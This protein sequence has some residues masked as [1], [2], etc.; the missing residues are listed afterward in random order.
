MSQLR[1]DPTTREWVIIA[2]E[3]AARPHSF[4]RTP[5]PR[6]TSR[7]GCPFCPGQESKTPPE[8]LVYAQDGGW[9]VRVVPNL[10]AA[11]TPGGSTERQIADGHFMAM[12]GVGAH[13]VVI[14][15]PDHD[16]P[17]ALMSDEEVLA[18]LRAY[19]ERYRALKESPN[20]SFV[21]IFKNH[22][23]RAGTSLDHPHSQIVATP[24]APL[25]VR[26]KFEIATDYY[27]ARGSCLYCDV[28]KWEREA[29]KRVVA[30][31]DGFVVIHPYASRSPFETWILPKTH[32]PCFD[33]AEEQGLLDLARVLRT[34]LRKIYHALG[35]PDFNYIL[36]TAPVDDEDNPYFLCHIQIVPRLTTVAGFEMGSGIYINT[37]LPEDTAR[38]M[39]EFP[40]D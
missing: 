25:R 36:H 30:E 16:R 32:Q 21:V 40:D 23:A 3:R 18:I 39:R 8:V 29:G 14:E 33:F 22:G 38:F 5:E 27:D 17:M 6:P 26:R 13:E 9:R 15:T 20:V 35:D 34:T 37:A 10:Y 31:N 24:I 11:L 2:T 12:D 7:E 4:Q 28:V 1:R 19:Q